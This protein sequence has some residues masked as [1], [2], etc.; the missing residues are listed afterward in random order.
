MVN[1]NPV[2]KP[3]LLNPSQGS[4]GQALAAYSRSVYQG[5]C[6]YSGDFTRQYLGSPEL[7]DAL[8]YWRNHDMKLH[9]IPPISVS[10]EDS[11]TY[12]KIK[13]DLNSYV[14]EWVVKAISGAVNVEEFDTVYLKTLNDIG[15][16]Q[17]VAI[18]Q[19][20]LDRYNNR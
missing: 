3:R 12:N 1:G 8:S 5:P 16:D 17:A 2:I 11:R 14:S 7:Q 13:S 10:V 9:I 6:E 19:A 15:L 18:Y 20:A 4:V